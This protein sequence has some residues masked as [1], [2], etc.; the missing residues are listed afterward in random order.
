M[1]ET[2][3][4]ILMVTTHYPYG[5]IQENWIAPELE[6]LSRNFSKVYILPVK[7]LEGRREL[8]EGT[9]LWAPLAGRNRMLFFS[10]QALR[11]LTWQYFF[12]ALKECAAGPGLTRSRVIVCFKFSCYRAAFETSPKLDNFLTSKNSKLV[13]AYWGHLAALSIPKARTRG[14]KTCVRYHASDL[15]VHRPET[16]GFYPFR[17]ELNTATDL[18]V[19]ISEHG[20]QYFS[21]TT[22]APQQQNTAVGRLGSHDYGRP[23]SSASIDS[24][25]IIVM[26]SASWIEPVKRVEE[27][28]KLAGALARHRKVIWHHFGDGHMEKVDEAARV[29]GEVGAEIIFHGLVPVERL[30]KF[31]RETEVS[32]FVNLSRDEGI[33]V[34]IMEAMNANIPIVATDVGGTAEVVIEG[35]SGILLSPDLNNC[36]DKIAHQILKSLEPNGALAS[37]CPRQVWEELC[38]AEHLASTFAERLQLLLSR[39]P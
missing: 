18:N 4:E 16:G 1:K 28:A 11:L 3:R 34:S 33:P 5:T 6:E 27:I 10:R 35:K 39:R 14:A 26:V 15:Y 37:S 17:Q 2:R 23:I 12:D 29:A 19:F 30:Q 22:G 24:N 25:R 7:E 32:F 20:R 38:D 13:Y 36:H 9:D 21:Q 31:Y 8:P